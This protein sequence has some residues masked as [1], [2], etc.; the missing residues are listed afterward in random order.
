[1]KK[2]L[3]FCLMAVSLVANVAHGGVLSRDGIATCRIAV[4]A[5]ATDGFKKEVA[6]FADFL[7]E[8]GGAKFEIVAEDADVPAGP[9]V[10]VGDTAY[11]RKA[12]VVQE[13][14]AREQYVVRTVGDDVIL[15]GAGELGA[16]Y[17]CYEF[18]ER[19]GY[20]CYDGWNEH[21]PKRTRLETGSLDINRAP[22]FAFRTIFTQT[23]VFSWGPAPAGDRFVRACKA[24]NCGF[25]NRVYGRPGDVHTFYLFTKDWQEQHPELLAK[26]A[27]G[28][29]RA[30]S[31][32]HGP[33]FCIT[34]PQSIALMKAK[35]RDFIAQ[36]RAEAKRTGCRPP[37]IYNISQNDGSGYLC[38]C[39][40]C[41]AFEREHNASGL[42]LHL[43][44]ELARDIAVDYPDVR[45]ETFAYC[46]TEPPPKGIVAG[47]NVI[48]EI[49]NTKGNYYAAVADDDRTEYPR[50]LKTWRQFASALAIWDYWVF[51][52]DAFPAPYHNLGWIAKD[53]RHYRDLGVRCLRIESEAGETANFFAFKQWLG[54][55]LMD[56]VDRDVE[57]LTDDFFNGYYG[58][59]AREMRAYA[60]YLGERQKGQ[61]AQVFVKSGEAYRVP[62]RPWLDAAFYAK[63]EELFDRAEAKVAND[64]R[65]LANVHRERIPVDISLLNVYDTVRPVLSREALA[66]RYRA[67]AIEHINARVRKEAVAGRI[68]KLDAELPGYLKGGE[69]AQRKKAGPPTLAVPRAP[70]TVTSGEWPDNRG[71]MPDRKVNLTASLC[72]GNRL[73]LVFNETGRAYAPV[74]NKG[75]PWLADDWEV[76]LAHERGEAYVQFI[77]TPSG[78][79]WIIY[80]GDR[81]KVPA[82]TAKSEPA[83][84]SWRAELVVPLDELPVKEV[85]RAG[86]FHSTKEAHYSW[87]PTFFSS[88]TA[89]EFLGTISFET[90][91]EK[92]R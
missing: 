18:L 6:R 69:I 49:C 66:A 74:E 13:G 45:I 41:A 60:D 53:L 17:A 65:T 43:I 21:V 30:L 23:G 77:V 24:T 85:R 31:G 15:G 36:D 47:P 82:V 73:R 84:D 62:P 26:T 42:L 67:N 51:Y 20:R 86:F 29:P 61:Y 35:L 80:K 81:I 10:S 55:K 87:S 44:N 68:A 54:F 34:D 14:L 79:L 7:S 27:E 16:V 4:P 57:A 3:I 38:K 89:T 75:S 50:L 22:T 83:K 59:A 40:R 39:P 11:A 70:E 25:P 91:K 78:G 12:G 48:I 90:V 2:S 32:Q 58:A 46:F 88:L 33:N 76:I 72:A 52:W 92:N 1:M 56:D 71:F 64:P 28:K 63:A 37:L 9:V 5:H 8:M 19:L